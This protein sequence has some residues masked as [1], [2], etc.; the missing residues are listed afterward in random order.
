[1][2]YIALKYEGGRE[3][4]L[5]FEE[6]SLP[7]NFSDLLKDATELE[8]SQEGFIEEKF[9][10]DCLP[11]SLKSL[12]FTGTCVFNGVAAGEK[13]ADTLATLTNLQFFS[14]RSV[15][16][17]DNQFDENEGPEYNRRCNGALDKIIESLPKSLKTFLLPHRR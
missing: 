6:E 3:T 14:L 2:L 9:P 5:Q 4:D 13:L 11:K 10:F 16:L 12:V 7:S 15:G 8:I 17:F 1:M